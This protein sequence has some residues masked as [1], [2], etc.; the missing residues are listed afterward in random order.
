V[1]IERD[2]VIDDF[3]GDMTFQEA[4]EHT[5][6]YINISIAPAERHQTSR[7]MNAITSPNVTIRSACKASSSPPSMSQAVE[8]EAKDS[9]GRLKPYLRNRRWVDGSFA[10]DLP[11]KRLSRLFGVNH[12][13]VS[14]INPIALPFMKEDPKTA[15][16]N[17]I[18]SAKRILFVALKESIK[19]ARRSRLVFK[20]FGVEEMLGTLY[21]LLDQQYF[22]D[23]N[24]ILDYS[25]VKGKYLLFEFRDESEVTKLFDSGRRSAWSKIEQIRNATIISRVIDD[26]L[27]RLEDEALVKRHAKQKL[28]LTI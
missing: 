24:M 17:F 22:G 3:C 27:V 9:R 16:Q 14:M 25:D 12:F 28:H 13:I 15:D 19:T 1:R 20:G 4:Y 6:R 2:A 8:L 5:G 23:I 11:I 10:E 7:L 21:G 18:N 26:I